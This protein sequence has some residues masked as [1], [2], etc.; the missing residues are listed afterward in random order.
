MTFIS[1]MINQLYLEII[2]H[3]HIIQL[4]VR[5]ILM[6]QICNGL[7]FLN[8]EQFHFPIALV[9]ER[10]GFFPYYPSESNRSRFS[11]NQTIF[12]KYNQFTVN[13]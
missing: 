10:L 5:L 4:K 7:V 9:V 3:V 6:N 2:I 1:F 13:Y 12:T 8:A 11:S